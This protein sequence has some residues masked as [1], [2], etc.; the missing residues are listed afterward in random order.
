MKK[1]LHTMITPVSITT[2]ASLTKFLQN[3]EARLV[4]LHGPKIETLIVKREIMGGFVL[5]NGFT[6]QID[7][8]WTANRNIIW[9]G[10]HTF[11]LAMKGDPMPIQMKEG[12]ALVEHEHHRGWVATFPQRYERHSRSFGGDFEAA[13]NH[14]HLI[15]E[16]KGYEKVAA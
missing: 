3:K 1:A 10:E 2:I 15:T 4:R 7:G 6:M 11:Y 14:V 13:W 5:S 16:E 9:A 12:V 8:R